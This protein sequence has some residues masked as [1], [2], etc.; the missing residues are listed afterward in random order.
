MELDKGEGL[1]AGGVRVCVSKEKD[2]TPGGSGEQMDQ[3]SP[4]HCWRDG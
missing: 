2:K 1:E 3:G 4:S